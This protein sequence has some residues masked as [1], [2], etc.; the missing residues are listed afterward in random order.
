MQKGNK[1]YQLYEDVSRDYRKNKTLFQRGVKNPSLKIFLDELK[2]RNIQLVNDEDGG[3][4][5][6]I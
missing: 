5:P 2:R 4:T 6:K 3:S 1:D